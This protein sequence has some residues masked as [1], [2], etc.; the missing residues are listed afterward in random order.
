MLI[1]GGDIDIYTL[2][3]E[4][5]DKN[6]IYQLF[7]LSG[8]DENTVNALFA[9]KSVYGMDIKKFK[10]LFRVGTKTGAAGIIELSEMQEIY[11]NNDA[12][13]YK[14]AKVVERLRDEELGIL[15]DIR[16]AKEAYQEDEDMFRKIAELA[17]EREEG[18]RGV[19]TIYELIELASEYGTESNIYK[20]FL[21][22]A[23]NYGFNGIIVLQRAIEALKREKSCLICQG[24]EKDPAKDE[25]V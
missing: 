10:T 6:F 13:F 12:I 9:H 8:K 3:T 4:K 21:D 14:L 5:A 18:E 17:T 1:C 20:V 2:L 11:R 19:E 24:A 22:T 25:E 16:V 7:D 15:Q 23:V